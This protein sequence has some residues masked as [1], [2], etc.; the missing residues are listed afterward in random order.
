MKKILSYTLVLITLMMVSCQ[1][2]HFIKDKNY[3][4][5]IEKDFNQKIENLGKSIFTIKRGDVSLKEMEAL[6][7]MYAYMPLGDI[8][9]HT[10]EFYLKNIRSSFKVQEE[11][12]WKISDELFRHFVL[13]IRINNENLDS[14]RIVFAKELVQ[15]VKGKSMYDAVLEVNHWCHEKMIYKPTDGRTSSPLASVKTAYGRCGEESTFAVA[16]FRAVGIPARQVYTPRWAHTDDNHAWVEV[17]ADGKWY[18]LG[19]CEPEPVLNL[20]WFNAPVSRGMLMDTKVFGHYCGKEEKLLENSNYTVINVTQNYAA[21]SK[22]KVVA[23]DNNDN[24]IEGARI[25]FK[26]YNYAEFYSIATKY[27]NKEGLTSLT[28]GQGD[29]L[30]WASYKGKYKFKKVTFGKD[31][32]VNIVL[33]KSEDVNNII[34]FN[35][36][37]PIEHANVPEVTA[38]QR[39]DNDKRKSIEDSIRNSYVA[40][41]MNKTKAENFLKK[42]KIVDNIDLSADITNILIDSRGNHKVISNFLY[43]NR[44]EINRAIKLLKLLTKK[45]LRDVTTDVLDDNML[46]RNSFLNPRVESEMLSPYKGFFI[47]K[48]KHSILEEY[49]EDPSILVEWC[50]NNISIDEN[51]YNLIPMSPMGVWNLRKAD[52]R[53]LNIFFVTLAR[54]AGIESRKDD[55]TGKIQYKNKDG[56]WIDVNFN[57]ST[58]KVSSKGELVLFYKPTKYLNDPKYYYNFSISKIENGIPDLLNYDL[59]N[60]NDENGASYNYFKKGVKMDVGNYVLV[61]GTRLASGKVLSNLIFFSIK[62][63]ETTKLELLIREATNLIQVIGSFNSESK[64]YSIDDKIDMSFLQKAGRGY[65]VVGILGVNQEP[66]NHALKDIASRSKELERWGRKIILLFPSKGDM[67]KYKSEY[68]LPANVVYGIDKDGSIQ[69]QITHN[70]KLKNKDLLPIFIFTDTFNR[71]IFISQGY[72][73]GLGERIM[74]VV[75]GI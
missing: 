61:T 25:D 74:K 46:A 49:K 23:K 38:K 10:N 1:K 60:G 70:M 26:I 9:N 73:I 37:P 56:L 33:D 58:S 4:N 8:A 12:N 52:I 40:T 59:G 27:T 7:F 45:D 48:I 42:L 65:F 69:K 34:A 13:P 53:S 19:A 55:I 15:K 67:N 35:Q 11:L 22:L 5:R 28:A 72:T 47:N 24:N 21:V 51:A 62:A 20:A 32:L 31:T 75:N 36:T 39:S 68:N 3:R 50:K 17:W 6:E 66:T 41:F 57:K 29:M 63:D 14:S 30:I 16:A 44:K 64:F 2:N 71:V 18:F 43:K 54:T